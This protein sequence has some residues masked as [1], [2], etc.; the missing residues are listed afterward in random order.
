MQVKSQKNRR[1]HKKN[2]KFSVKKNEIIIFRRRKIEKIVKYGHGA[3]GK[4]AAFALIF[5][6]S[7]A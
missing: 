4:Y 2:E 6:C 3:R 5:A 7:F 1:F